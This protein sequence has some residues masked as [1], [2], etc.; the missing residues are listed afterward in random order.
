MNN[1]TTGDVTSAEAQELLFDALSERW[2][3]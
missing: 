1:P 3:E 2:K